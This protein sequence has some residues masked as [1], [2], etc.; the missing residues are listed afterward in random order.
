MEAG[1]LITFLKL[2]NIYGLLRDGMLLSSGQC[3]KFMFN[4]KGECSDDTDCGVQFL[5]VLPLDIWTLRTVGN[6][7]VHAEPFPT[8]ILHIC[9]P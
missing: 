4:V 1:C 6:L 8:F 5:Q 2:L 7:H 9:S 3:L